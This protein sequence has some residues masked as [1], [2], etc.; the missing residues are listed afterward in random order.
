MAKMQIEF[1]WQY[2]YHRF[3][4]K[5]QEMKFSVTR[6]SVVLS[7]NFAVTGFS[8]TG[9]VL[10]S[11]SGGPVSGRC[12]RDMHLGN[13]NANIGQ[14]IFHQILIINLQMPEYL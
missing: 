7:Q 14:L 13:V 12:T 11:K 9:L 5:P 6:G 1:Q 3:D 10:D 8:V 4:V 2:H